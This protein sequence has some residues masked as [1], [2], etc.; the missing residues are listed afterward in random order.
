[1]ARAVADSLP[2]ATHRTRPDGLHGLDEDRAWGAGHGARVRPGRDLQ[3]Y[4]H[5]PRV[6]GI[7]PLTDQALAGVIM[8]VEQTIVMGVALVWLFI[9]ALEESE[10]EQQRRE[11]LEAASSQP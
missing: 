1:M 4:V 5:Q 8:A 7:S 10:R 3:L 9:H 6:W 11:R 2:P